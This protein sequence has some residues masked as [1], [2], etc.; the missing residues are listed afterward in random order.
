MNDSHTN[1]A[2]LIKLG[3]ALGLLAL[4]NVAVFGGLFNSRTLNLHWRVLATASD[5]TGPYHLVQ[6]AMSDERALKSIEVQRLSDNGEVLE[7]VWKVN[8]KSGPLDTFSFGSTINGME[9]TDDQTGRPRLRPGQT[10]RI[11][12]RASGFYKGELAFET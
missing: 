6:F 3:S 1:Y 4:I 10:Y 8:G 11:Q 5:D 2:R 9:R 7:T 12:V